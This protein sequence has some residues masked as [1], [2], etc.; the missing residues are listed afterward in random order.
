MLASARQQEL[1]EACL[2]RGGARVGPTGSFCLDASSKKLSGDAGCVAP[3][4]AAELGRLFANSS[5]LDLGAGA[6]LY[7]RYFARHARSVRWVGVDG[8]ENVEEASGGRVRFPS[9]VRRPGKTVQS[10]SGPAVS[11]G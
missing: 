11:T 3:R 2:L 5:V 7:G 10:G 9:C 8:A 1:K 4:L 6:G